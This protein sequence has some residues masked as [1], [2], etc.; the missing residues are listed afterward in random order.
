MFSLTN[1]TLVSIREEFGT[2]I[3]STIRRAESILFDTSLQ[4][5][6]A[7]FRYLSRLK[8]CGF[9]DV[10]IVITAIDA[11]EYRPDECTFTEHTE[12]E[13]DVSTCPDLAY[14][15]FIL[16][17]LWD[18]QN[19]VT[20]QYLIDDLTKIVTGYIKS[21]PRQ[22]HLGLLVA[23]HSTYWW[24]GKIT[25]IV[26]VGDIAF[27]FV[28]YPGHQFINSDWIPA[29]SPNIKCFY[30]S[31]GERIEQAEFLSIEQKSVMSQSEF[32]DTFDLNYGVW[33][34]QQCIP[35]YFEDRSYA[36]YASL[37]TFTS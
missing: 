13:L 20:A 6:L 21:Y 24:S 5:L 8:E 2:H 17:P 15:K 34:R 4:Q 30:N 29:L 3:L 23:V 33:T 35:V 36:T 37:G 28:E 25:K 19:R 12:I 18:E 9:I 26:N 27:L 1:Q 16:K 7:I 32:I 14:E 10:P 22:Y 31:K 11:G